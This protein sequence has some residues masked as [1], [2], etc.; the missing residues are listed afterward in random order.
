MVSSFIFQTVLLCNRISKLNKKLEKK[1]AKAKK[2]VNPAVGFAARLLMT[3]RNVSGT[4][5]IDDGTMLPGS[6]Q[7]SRILGMNSNNLG[8]SSFAFGKQSYDIWGRENGFNIAAS[9]ASIVF[10]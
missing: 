1:E 7:E 3:V 9:N 8:M 5:T 4:Y 10:S 6:N 2:K